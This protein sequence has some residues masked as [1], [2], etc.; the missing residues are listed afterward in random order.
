MWRFS[1]RNLWGHKRRLLTTSLAVII[2]VAFLS[3]TL[4]LRDT[5]RKTFD[6]LFAG[7]Y[8]GTDAVV[9]ANGEFDDPSGFG[10]QRGRISESLL[11]VRSRG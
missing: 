3:G 1:I 11:A 4:V 8:A 5:M 6:D 7:V 9:R 2:G 10:V